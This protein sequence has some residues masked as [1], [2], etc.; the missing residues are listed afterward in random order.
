MNGEWVFR[1]CEGWSRILL[2]VGGVNKKL[3]IGL[4]K[5]K[6]ICFTV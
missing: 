1:Y 5:R 4:V 6:E 3:I 2:T